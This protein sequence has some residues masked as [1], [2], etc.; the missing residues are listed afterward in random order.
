MNSLNRYLL[1]GHVKENKKVRK[2]KDK[3][4]RKE[5]KEITPSRDEVV[6]DYNRDDRAEVKVV[7][8]PEVEELVEVTDHDAEG[9]L[10]MSEV[11]RELAECNC[12]PATPVIAEDVVMRL[13][14][15]RFT[16]AA[17]C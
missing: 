10:V 7:V 9:S 6:T 12:T 8:V 11:E 5:K 13:D 15:G 2:K 3:E 17:L 4:I 16:D 1:L 14:Q